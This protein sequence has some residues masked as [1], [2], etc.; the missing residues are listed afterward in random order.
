MV[1]QP[2]LLRAVV[3]NPGLDAPRL[4]YADWCA[5]IDEED[6]RARA[7]L[8]RAQIGLL[9]T[10]PEIV[11]GGGAYRRQRQVTA[12]LSRWSDVWAEPLRPFVQSASFQRGFVG[13]VVMTA[14]Q[15]LDSAGRLF[16]LAPIQHVNL[17]AF[18]DLRGELLASPFLG[19]LRSLSLDGCGLT[20][21]DMRA[22]GSTPA[23]L[24][25]RWLS[26][27]NN[28]LD[29]EGARAIAASPIFKN[30]PV[31]ELEGNP[32]D[33]REELG[34]EGGEVVDATLPESGRL[35]EREFGPLPWLHW[36][37]D[38]SRFR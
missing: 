5:T 16:E 18:R 37:P 8:I 4:A 19:R 6:M 20:A 29:F 35:L 11:R 1:E 23:L 10:S 2:D 28:E 30:L 21:D 31:I 32:V 3:E 15:F 25:L 7:E 27:R 22:L 34:I 9:L 17:T 13:Q 36:T 26:L 12:L 14:H 38:S 24:G 33:P